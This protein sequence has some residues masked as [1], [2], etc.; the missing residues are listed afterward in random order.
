MD[1]LRLWYLE[2]M[3]D[4]KP[5]EIYF[6]YKKDDLEPVVVRYLNKNEVR[7]MELYFDPEI[8]KNTKILQENIADYV[9]KRIDLEDKIND[10]FKEIEIA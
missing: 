3:D 4:M 1:V 9:T 7:E 2:N 5:N 8:K 10:I 6:S